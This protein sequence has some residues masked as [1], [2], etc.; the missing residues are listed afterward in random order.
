MISANCPS[1]TSKG[2]S[3][4]CAAGKK[5]IIHY[6]GNIKKVL[7]GIK[8]INPDAVHTIEAPPTGDCTLT[9]AR[10]ALGKEIILIGHIQYEDIRSMTRE[11]MRRHV[12]DVLREG[13]S[14]RFILSPTAGP[15]E[16][17]ISENM[18]ENY[19]EIL[20]TGYAY[21]RKG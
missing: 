18:Q 20:R 6:H 11:Q 16:E 8:E 14:G 7:K 4:W 21:G 12:K 3:T 5:S 17:A 19:I 15:Y 2:W 9:E 10:E 1:G 13:M